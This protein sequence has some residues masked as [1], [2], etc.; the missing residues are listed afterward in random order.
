MDSDNTM[1]RIAGV[2]GSTVLGGGLADMI[3]LNVWFGAAIMVG[4][5]WFFV[6]NEKAS[7]V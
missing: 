7:R 6:C 2:L 3:G 1:R 4:I 5:Y